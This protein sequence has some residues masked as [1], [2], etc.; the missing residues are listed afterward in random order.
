MAW[1]VQKMDTTSQKA[2]PKGTADL[3]SAIKEEHCTAHLFLSLLKFQFD[4]YRSGRT[5]IINHVISVGY[6]VKSMHSV[7]AFVSD[8]FT[9]K[10]IIFMNYPG[11]LSA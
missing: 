5:N 8:S 11:C 3:I 4:L 7:T 6:N 2:S 9:G 10:P 1:G